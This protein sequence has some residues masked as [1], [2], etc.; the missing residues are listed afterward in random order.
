[1][2][3]FLAIFLILFTTIITI[4]QVQPGIEVEGS[5]KVGDDQ[6]NNPEPGTIRWNP[7]T[8]DFEGWTGTVWK[9]LTLTGNEGW[10]NKANTE[11]CELTTSRAPGNDGYGDTFGSSVAISGDVAIIG[12]PVYDTNGNQNQGSAYIFVKSG[13]YWVVARQLVS[14]DGASND[15]FGSTV[16]ISGDVAIVGAPSHDI[17]G[18]SNKGKA[19]VYV[20]PIDGWLTLFDSPPIMQ[21]VTQLIANGGAG[22]DHFGGAV[23]VSE[24]VIIVGASSHDTSGNPDEGKA[25]LF[26]KPIGGW[27]VIM[28]QNTVMTASNGSSD[29]RFGASVAIS[30]DWVIIGSQ[31]HDTNG[32]TDFGA[33]YLYLKPQPFGWPA[34]MTETKQ[35]YASDAT[36]WC[37]FGSSVSINKDIAVVGAPRSNVN[38]NERQ[39][40]AYVY[41]RSPLFGWNTTESARLLASDG[42]SID[43]F[44]KVSI[45]DNIIV[46]GASIHDTKGKIDQGKAYIFETPIGGWSSTLTESSQISA[47]D[48]ERSSQFG[49]SVS[50]SDSV[51]LIG[52]RHHNIGSISRQGKAY[53]FTSQ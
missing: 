26:E 47:S 30:Q 46:V 11:N 38:G 3:L 21:E 14:S 22:N 18:I 41:V 42:N 31:F 10:G 12:S 7:T 44:G 53:I 48:G 51:V 5:I 6:S 28:A 8:E 35:I 33:A 40:K 24:D 25:Y 39:G 50:V 27:P 17:N 1:M 36:E 20:K 52:A 9:S 2:K 49:S 37:G 32:N 34:S 29:D 45:S 13:T 16:A 19:Y 23:A 43:N 4:A 15:Y